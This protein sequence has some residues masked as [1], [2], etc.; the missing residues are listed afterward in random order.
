[1]IHT[2]GPV[3]SPREDRA[4]LLRSCHTE[5]LRVADALGCATVAFPAI[6]TGVYG[7]PK[8]EAARIALA[9]MRAHD[10]SFDRI[11]A[12]L[13]DASAAEAYLR[14]LDER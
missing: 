9:V 10:D 3:Y 8:P 6:S 5:A 7:Y 12:C 14:I 13:F 11:V 4:T 1:M 2:V